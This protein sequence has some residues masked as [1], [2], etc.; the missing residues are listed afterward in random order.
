MSRDGGLFSS[1]PLPPPYLLISLRFVSLLL[2]FAGLDRLDYLARG[3][4]SPGYVRY[5]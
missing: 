2:N 1:L 5:A 3:P 4:F